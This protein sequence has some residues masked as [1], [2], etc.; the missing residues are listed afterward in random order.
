MGGLP[1]APAATIGADLVTSRSLLP[2]PA[3]VPACRPCCSAYALALCPLARH[4]RTS[5]LHSADLRRDRF[6]A[7]IL[8]DVWCMHDIMQATSRTRTQA[9]CKGLTAERLLGG[10]LPWTKMRQAYALISLCDKYGDGRVEAI[11]QSALAFDV[12]SVTRVAKMLKAAA[13]PTR[14]ESDG[15]VVQLPLPRFV[16]PTEHFATQPSSSNKN[17]VK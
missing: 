17:E 12:V 3:N 14:P 10:P 9:A 4:A 13:K 6:A 2:Q 5:S 8:F 11:C 16:R 15:K 7:L 1:V